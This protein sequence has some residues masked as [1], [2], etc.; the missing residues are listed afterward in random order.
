MNRKEEAEINALL[1]NLW[2]RNQPL[3][4]ERLDA[5][6]LIAAE[7][8]AGQM[9]ETSRKNG[10]D[11]AH[12]LSGSLGMFGY[13]RGTEIAREIEQILTS[14]TPETMANL[15]V[16]ATDLRQLLTKK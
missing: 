15:S 1:A 10:L 3:L 5:L 16:L 13:D 8:A 14:P 9:T 6:D 4:H 12:K 7:A 2:E 11:I